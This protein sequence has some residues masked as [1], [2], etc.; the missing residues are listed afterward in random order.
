MLSRALAPL[1]LCVSVLAP[2]RAI[3]CFN[4]MDASTREFTQSFWVDLILWTLGAVFLNRVVLFNG[5]GTTAEERAS[6][7]GLRKAFLLL[8]SAALVLLLA[9]VSAGGPL[10]NFSSMDFARCSVS[11]TMLLVLVASPAVLFSL[12]AVVFHGP[13]RRLFRDRGGVALAS[14]VLTSVLLA[15]GLGKVR[16]TY[17]LPHLCEA[18]PQP[19]RG[20][21]AMFTNTYQ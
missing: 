14:L 20:G 21:G 15:T 4:S 8:V 1:L 13:G 17:I 6:A 18:P 9:T 12:Q 2:L 16:E 19:A 7:S 5:L 3:A 10:L 11:R